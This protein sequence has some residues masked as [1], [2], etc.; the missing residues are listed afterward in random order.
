MREQHGR[1]VEV[2]LNERALCNAEIRPEQL[3]KIGE[4]NLSTF[5]A[6][7]GVVDV[8]GNQ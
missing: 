4:P 3:A 6:H 7:R 2:V 5:N 1:D 8:G